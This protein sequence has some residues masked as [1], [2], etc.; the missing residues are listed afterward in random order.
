MALRKS[1]REIALEGVRHP[2]PRQALE[3]S[4]EESEAAIAQFTQQ[5]ASEGMWKEGGLLQ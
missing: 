5:K 3:L 2:T 1:I 4:I